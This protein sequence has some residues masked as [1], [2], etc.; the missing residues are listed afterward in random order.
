MSCVV[1]ARNEGVSDL[2]FAGSWARK[3]KE[4]KANPFADMSR[5]FPS[6][7]ITLLRVENCVVLNDFAPWFL[8]R[9]CRCIKRLPETVT[10]ISWNYLSNLLTFSTAENSI[11][12][13]TYLYLAALLSTSLS[14]NILTT[15]STTL[16]RPLQTPSIQSSISL[17]IQSSYSFIF[18][19]LVITQP[20]IISGILSRGY[21]RLQ[22]H[23]CSETKSSIF[24]AYQS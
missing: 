19:G 21:P 8:A 23:L 13:S 24:K 2:R 6:S 10:W 4:N 15:S 9:R 11:S 12:T 1:A 16:P 18:S 7:W 20:S 22:L 3:L 17:N 14:F 5:K